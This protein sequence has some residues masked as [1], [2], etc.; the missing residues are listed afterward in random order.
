MSEPMSEKLSRFTPSG[1]GLDRDALLFAAGRASARPNCWWIAA[2]G[3]LAAVQVLTLVLLW[4]RPAPAPAAPAMVETVPPARPI[5]A[6]FKGS[7]PPAE[8]E[9]TSLLALQRQFLEDGPQVVTM[10]ASEDLV[11]A[12]P[13]L[14]AI[15][16]SDAV[17]AN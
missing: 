12:S 4:P 5:P 15:A 17:F 6:P 3:T 10:S 16:I 7:P 2:A 14:R 13:P 9:G 8:V 11:P 1:A